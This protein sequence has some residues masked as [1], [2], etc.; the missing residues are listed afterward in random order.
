MLPDHWTEKWLSESFRKDVLKTAIERCD[1]DITKLTKQR[2]AAEKRLKYLKENGK[3]LHVLRLYYV[4]P[5][6][7]RDDG[8]S[9]GEYYGIVILE[10]FVADDKYGEP[11]HAESDKAYTYDQVMSL[12]KKYKKKMDSKYKSNYEIVDDI[13]DDKKW[14]PGDL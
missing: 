5:Y 8:Y 4:E 9:H 10:Y 14:S 6:N 2:D 3:P 1:H 7:S 13:P 12:F 11:V